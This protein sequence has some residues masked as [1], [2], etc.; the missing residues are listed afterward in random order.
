MISGCFYKND[1][2][3]LNKGIEFLVQ[4]TS[5]VS[6]PLAAGFCI[7]SKEI[8]LLLF[9]DDSAI[10][11]APLL[12]LVSPAMIFL[13]LLT[14][15]NTVL[16]ATE[17]VVASLASMGIGA[18]IKIITSYILMRDPDIGIAGAPLGTVISYGISL[19]ISVCLM[20]RFVK[21]KI[22]AFKILFKPLFIG[23][24]SIIFS[25][26]VYNLI[27]NRVF[28]ISVFALSVS[29]AVVFYFLLSI[30]FGSFSFK[31]IKTMSKSTKK[32][33]NS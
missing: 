6:F 20:H 25:K 14:I 15:I 24:G 10:I 30:F 19:I 12:T 13:P 33:E 9:N 23:F 31:K 1:F 5:F 27:T 3:G 22:S 11:A 28:S 17:R 8:L 32:V 7:Y 21:I 4:M 26:L 29:I 18:A 2:K 16:E